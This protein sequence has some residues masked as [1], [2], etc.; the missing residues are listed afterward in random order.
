LGH[1]DQHRGDGDLTATAPDGVDMMAGALTV[2]AGDDASAA[3]WG[4][5]APMP[6]AGHVPM[7]ARLSYR[8]DPSQIDVDAGEFATEQTHVAFSGQTAWG[9]QSAF[10][11][12]VVSRDWQESDEILAGILTAFGS[13]TG[14]VAFAGRGEF[15]GAMAGP[16]RRPRVEGRF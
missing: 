11:F 2:R 7:A 3:A 4:P 1:F 5:F 9:D 15:D 6:L 14:P 8:Y 12:K 10:R 13:S 16:F